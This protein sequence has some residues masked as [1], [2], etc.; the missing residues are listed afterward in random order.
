MYNFLFTE[1]NHNDY[2]VAS[3]G[4]PLMLRLRHAGLECPNRIA[5]LLYRKSDGFFEF[6]RFVEIA[7]SM[8]YLNGASVHGVQC[9]GGEGQILVDP[10][11]YHDGG[12]YDQALR[13]KRSAH[14]QE[15]IPGLALLLRHINTIHAIDPTSQQ[16]VVT[17][18]PTCFGKDLRHVL[19]QLVVPEKVR[20]I[21]IF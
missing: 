12:H 18:D 2:I 14:R 5:Y 16:T 3:V 1:K 15:F 13:Q 4:I 10:T 19:K 8:K 9:V 20:F 11:A 21:V 6:D 17:T 7:R